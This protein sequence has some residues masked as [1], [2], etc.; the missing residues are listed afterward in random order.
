MRILITGAAGFVGQ[1]LAEQL[2]NEGHR[3][4]LTDIVEPPI[5]SAA[6]NRGN[7]KTVKADLY[8]EAAK[9][10][11]KDLEAAFIFHGIMSAGSEANFELGYRVNVHSTFR[12]LD[13]LRKACPGVRVVYASSCAIY[14][15]PIPEWPSEATVPTPESSYG[16]QKIICEDLINDYNRRGLINA[17]SLRFP[18]ISVRP[19][20]PTQAAS[21]FMS[22]IIREPLQ[23][24]DSEL[25]VEDDFQAWLCSPRTLVTNLIHTLTIPADALPP[26][27]R[28]VN[29]PG[30]TASVADMLKALEEVGGKDSLKHIKRTKDPSIEEMLNSWGVR[31]DVSKALSLGYKADE[32][33]KQAVV[34]FAD[35]LK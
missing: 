20:K 3:L 7:A 25:P 17:F 31:Y 19:G 2:L 5:P 35:T 32:S 1:L 14:G 29:L 11:E 12:I 4:L 9:V 23:G 27:I 10:A 34:D 26:H 15:R 24:K 21:S 13:E 16:C 8:E 6:R 33:F 28:Q 30:I 18:T 22:G